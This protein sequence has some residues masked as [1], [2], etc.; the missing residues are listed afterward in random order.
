[1]LNSFAV[2]GHARVPHEADNLAI[3]TDRKFRQ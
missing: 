2:F 1:V 3:G